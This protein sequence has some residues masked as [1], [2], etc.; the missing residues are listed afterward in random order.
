ME[1][2]QASTAESNARC[3]P[4]NKRDDDDETAAMK[5]PAYLDAEAD[6]PV[7]DIVEEYD[8]DG[9]LIGNFIQFTGRC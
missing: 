1:I 2:L 6:L 4:Q 9:K 7:V 8:A 3:S 5:K